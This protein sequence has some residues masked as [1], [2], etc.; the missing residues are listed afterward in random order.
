M[1]ISPLVIDYVN[2]D[3]GFRD[4][5]DGLT[6]NWA[7]ARNAVAYLGE[8]RAKAERMP[9]APKSSPG[10]DSGF[11]QSHQQWNQIPKSRKQCHTSLCLF[12]F[13]A[14][15]IFRFA[16]IRFFSSLE[17]NERQAQSTYA[18]DLGALSRIMAAQAGAARV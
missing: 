3:A 7:G 17:M 15:R 12:I 5:G 6:K 16:R 11:Q 13:W 10:A 8:A 2:W 9:C 1:E 4:G 14:Y 18:V